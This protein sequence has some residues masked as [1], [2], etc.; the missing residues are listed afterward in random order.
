MS[1][2]RSFYFDDVITSGGWEDFTVVR[3]NDA[4]RARAVQR[5]VG[6]GAVSANRLSAAV[7]V[8]QATLS[9]W[10]RDARSVHGMTKSSG[11]KGKRQ[12]NAQ[13]TGAEKLRV[14]MAAQGLS[15]TE[16]G[17][18]LRREGLHE[19]QLIDWR[20]AAVAALEAPVKRPS[21]APSADA[22]RNKELER[23]L[24][25]K[26]KALAETAA[27]LVLKKKVQAIW[28]DEDDFTDPRSAR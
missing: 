2:D 3:F 18:L 6:P 20:M 25:R 23:E 11:P 12:T 22:R 15:E 4:F 13:W 1:H 19:A 26:D 27:L 8:S 21:Q 28:G 5:M 16:L 10:L 7:G 17:A 14:V 24:R 9:R